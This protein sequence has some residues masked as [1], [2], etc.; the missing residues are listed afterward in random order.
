MRMKQS[1]LLSLFYTLCSSIIASPIK[2]YFGIHLGST[3]WYFQNYK[4]EQSNT[5]GLTQLPYSYVI[6][7]GSLGL[8]YT[9]SKRLGMDVRARYFRHNYAFNIRDYKRVEPIEVIIVPLVIQQ[10]WVLQFTGRV[11][12]VNKKHV[13]IGTNLGIELQRNFTNEHNA[14]AVIERDSSNGARQNYTDHVSSKFSQKNALVAV[15]IVRWDLEYKM[16][17]VPGRIR[18][19]TELSSS[20]KRTPYAVSHE[21]KGKY[22]NHS[23]NS[24]VGFVQTFVNLIYIFK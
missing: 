22:F 16:K 6:I 19:E 20:L 8:N 13:S 1:I 23:L 9:I 15:P 18:I 4:K 24:N 12:W 5:N 7:G 21:Y 14:S 2:P 3:Q 10:Q 11:V 17:N